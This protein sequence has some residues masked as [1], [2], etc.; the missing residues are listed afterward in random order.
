MDY[1]QKPEEVLFWP[2]L[3]RCFPGDGLS[4]ER[5]ELFVTGEGAAWLRPGARSRDL[6]VRCRR[7]EREDLMDALGPVESRHGAVA[8]VCGPAG[9]TDEIVGV[10]KEAEGMSGYRVLCEKWW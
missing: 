6:G 8:Y 5:M 2:R 3:V 7:M 4:T 9:M 10:L 1:G